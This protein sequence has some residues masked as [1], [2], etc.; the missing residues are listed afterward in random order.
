MLRSY[1]RSGDHG[2]NPKAAKTILFFAVFAVIALVVASLAAQPKPAEFK[3]LQITPESIQRASSASL[4][5][6]PPGSNTVTGRTTKPDEEF[7]IVTVKF[8]VTPAFQASTMLKRPT[9]TDS[10]GKIYNTAVSFVDVA[11]TPE[12][13]CSIPFRVP[14]GTALKSFN[15]ETASVDLA[16]V[17][18]K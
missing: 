6:C 15:V 9:V 17:D 18:K 13:S 10:A 12:F 4:K 7:A 8:K 14:T 5:D 11:A 1:L 2:L 16:A 3:G